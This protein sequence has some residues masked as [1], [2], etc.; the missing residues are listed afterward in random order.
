MFLCFI[1]QQMAKLK[2]LLDDA[3]NANSSLRQQLD[4][5]QVREM[6]DSEAAKKIEDSQREILELRRN[7][8]ALQNQNKVIFSAGIFIFLFC[9]LNYA[10][11]CFSE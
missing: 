6:E 9:N 5:S 10:P 4:L 7:I 8:D 2:S 1:R 11:Y 3:G